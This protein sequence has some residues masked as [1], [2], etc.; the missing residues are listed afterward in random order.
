M[1]L[2]TGL[3]SL[4]GG[5]SSTKA[6]RTSTQAQTYGGNGT[7]NYTPT[8]TPGQ[9]GMQGTV[10][11]A[12]QSQISGGVDTTPMATAGTNN[13]DTTYRGI[14]DRLQQNLSARGF[15][16]SGASGSMGL[17]TELG[18]AGAVGDLQS[19]LGGYALEQ[20]RQ[21]LGQGLQFGF[22]SPGGTGSSSNAGSAFDT[23]V[24]AGS[25]LA[26]AFSGGMTSLMQQLNMAAAAGGGY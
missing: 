24:G 2:M 21:A 6:A 17:Q 7:N 1:A 18:R 25:P 20:Q 22:A 19:Q 9:T 15:G 16:N 8:F 5:L 11:Q 23:N 12:L 3:S 14:G 13:I 4:L 26:G 10:G